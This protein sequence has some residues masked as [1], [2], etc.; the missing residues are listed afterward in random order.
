MLG[1]EAFRFVGSWED[2]FLTNDNRLKLN[3]FRPEN[4]ECGSGKVLFEPLRLE[5]DGELAHITQ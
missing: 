5:R 3:A 4:F 2:S 1:L